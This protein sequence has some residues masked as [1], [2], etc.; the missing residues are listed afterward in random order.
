M[1]SFWIDKKILNQ[2]E[3]SMLLGSGLSAVTVVAILEFVLAVYSVALAAS[4]K[5]KVLKIVH[6]VLAVVWV[7][8]AVLNLFF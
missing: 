2:E 5:N 7:V 4:T 1:Q 3:K 8:L 6:L